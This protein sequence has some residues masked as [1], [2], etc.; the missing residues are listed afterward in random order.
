MLTFTEVTS[1][2]LSRLQSDGNP[3]PKLYFWDVELDT[4]QYFNFENGRGEQDDY[5]SGTDGQDEDKDTN[6]AER[7]TSDL[8]CFV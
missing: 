5:P 6:D 7:C 1:V 4:V 3:D 2:L 8:S